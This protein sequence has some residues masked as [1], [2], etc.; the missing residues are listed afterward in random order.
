MKGRK[1]GEHRDTEG[2]GRLIGGLRLGY[3][4]SR[5]ERGLWDGEGP[6]RGRGTGVEHEEE[7]Y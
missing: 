3:G 1:G 5:S 7:S 6:K 2:I 4:G